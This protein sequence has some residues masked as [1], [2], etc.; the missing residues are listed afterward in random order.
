MFKCTHI[1]V[2]FV[3]LIDDNVNFTF[4]YNA[5]IQELANFTTEIEKTTTESVLSV[6]IKGCGCKL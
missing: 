2:Q 4:P 5:T 1:Y 3:E 6:N